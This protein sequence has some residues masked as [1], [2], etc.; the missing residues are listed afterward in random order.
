MPSGTRRLSCSSIEGE[1]E[2]VRTGGQ[3]AEKE[4]DELVDLM[5]HKT[6]NQARLIHTE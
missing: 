1:I 2:P 6:S 5:R 4:Q 3:E